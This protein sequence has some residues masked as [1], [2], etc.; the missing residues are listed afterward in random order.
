MPQTK[1]QK[2]NL[3][4]KTVTHKWVNLEKGRKQSLFKMKAELQN[5][6]KVI[7]LH[8]VLS[9]MTKVQKIPED[10]YLTC[11]SLRSMNEAPLLEHSLPEC[12]FLSC[13]LLAFLLQVLWQT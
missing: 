8:L 9:K 11:E 6:D 5:L 2:V 12:S 1:F 3:L 10:F 4:K 13:P 7:T